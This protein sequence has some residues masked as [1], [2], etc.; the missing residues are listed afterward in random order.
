MVSAIV[1]ILT[2]YIKTYDSTY[3]KFYS[4]ISVVSVA[5]AISTLYFYIRTVEVILTKNYR[6]LKY[7]KLQLIILATLFCSLSWFH[8]FYKPIPNTHTIN[9]AVITEIMRPT[10]FGN[11]YL[12]YL[13]IIMVFTNLYLLSKISKHHPEE[14]LL[15]IGI[16]ITLLAIVH[17][18]LSPLI[19]NYGISLFQYY[20]L[21]SPLKQQDFS[22]ISIDRLLQ[23]QTNLTAENRQYKKINEK[24]DTT[25]KISK[26]ILRVI[27]HDVGNSITALKFVN[28]QLDDLNDDKLI[29]LTPMMSRATNRIEVISHHVRELPEK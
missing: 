11:I 2:I 5:S 22:Y 9:S 20:L 25:I 16:F 10:I 18:C 21:A 19:P 28:K 14:R 27:S 12:M 29:K 17:D 1:Y 13:L 23:R 26:N 3:T 24:Q 15:R 8:I 6:L 4:I 7:I